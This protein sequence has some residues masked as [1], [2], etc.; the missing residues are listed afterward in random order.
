MSV[1]FNEKYATGEEVE[2]GPTAERGPSVYAR[3]MSRKGSVVNPNASAP[4]AGVLV[5]SDRAYSVVAETIPEFTDL[6]DEAREHA[7]KE[8]SM[9]FME[10]IKTY[11]NA[12]AWSVLLSSSIIMEG[13]D[14]NLLGSFFAFPV[15]NQQFGNELPS[16]QYQVSAPWQTGLMNGAQLGSMIGLAINGIMC[17]RLGYKKTYFFALA[18]MIAFIFLPFF[19]K[20]NPL[21]LAGQILSGIPWVSISPHSFSLR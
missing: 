11:P 2:N 6:H 21:L 9:G 3:R 8:T 10:G 19:A 7:E 1:K 5:N 14:T 20:G 18:M 17:D 12:V 16:G 15:F 4:P 13:Y